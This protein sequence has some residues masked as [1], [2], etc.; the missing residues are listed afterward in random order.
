MAA[1]GG[2]L[3]QMKQTPMDGAAPNISTERRP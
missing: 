1:A 3:I 2:L